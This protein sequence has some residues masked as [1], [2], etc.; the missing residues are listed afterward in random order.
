[1][2][3]VQLPPKD[4]RVFVAS[5]TIK[6]RSEETAAAIV[7]SLDAAEAFAKQPFVDRGGVQVQVEDINVM[8]P[9]TEQKRV[10]D[11]TDRLL[12]R[13]ICVLAALDLI[14]LAH[15]AFSVYGPP[16]WVCL[17]VAVSFLTIGFAVAAVMQL[18]PDRPSEHI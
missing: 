7:R 3:L 4:P 18:Q 2:S 13:V 1:M 15:I 10:E 5:Q 17:L 11:I 6:E 14:A 16:W 9:P 12:M 8:A